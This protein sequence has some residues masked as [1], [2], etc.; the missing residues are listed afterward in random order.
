MLEKMSKIIRMITVSPVMATIMLFVVN[1]SLPGSFKNITHFIVILLCL[2]V[3]PVL[4]Y[5]VSFMI[6]K[7]KAMGRNGQRGLAIAFSIVGYVFGGIFAIATSAPSLEIVIYLTYF[8][9]A[10]TLGALTLFAHK[11]VS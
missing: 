8:I 9:T 6:P 2:V 3:F 7:I 1:F 10:L 4:A 11:K 5:P